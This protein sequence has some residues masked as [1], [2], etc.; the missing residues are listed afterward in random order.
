[1]R[2]VC[3]RV[4]DLEYFI[5]CADYQQLQGTMEPASSRV[6]MAVE[7][8]DPRDNMHAGNH[9]GMYNVASTGELVDMHALSRSPSQN[10]QAPTSPTLPTSSILSRH[11][12]K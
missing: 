2:F 6:L 1:M 4:C 8:S 5:V 3:F 9:L 10:L 12:A 7:M 11:I